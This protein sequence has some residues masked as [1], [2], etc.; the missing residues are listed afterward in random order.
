MLHFLERKSFSGSLP[1]APL[2]D[3]S[4]VLNYSLLLLC[5][6][7]KN[8]IRSCT[9]CDTQMDWR[10]EVRGCLEFANQNAMKSICFQEGGTGR[11]NVL[12][13][14][15]LGLFYLFSMVSVMSVRLKGWKKVGGI[16]TCTYLKQQGGR[17]IQ[18]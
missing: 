6:I 8:E 13:A 12:T 1:P 7:N 9:I 11:F 4:C 10:P 14:C 18:L 17:A 3:A 15:M 16:C 5:I 2:P